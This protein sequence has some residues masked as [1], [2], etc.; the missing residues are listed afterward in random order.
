VIRERM[1]HMFGKRILSECE[2]VIMKAVWDA[3]E[4]ISIPDLITV[5]RE[6]YGKDYQ[7]TTVVTFLSRLAGKDYVETF[8][9]G[10]LSYA[11]PLKSEEEYK[12]YLAGR[13]LNRW[14]R[15]DASDYVSSLLK[16]RGISKE[17]KEKIRRLLDELDD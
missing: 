14:F 9:R 7:R 4:D 12:S 16:E 10:R 2:E 8:R 1:K 5:L 13:E 15:D 6:Q 17:E 11:R 3:G